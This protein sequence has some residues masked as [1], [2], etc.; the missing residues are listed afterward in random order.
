MKRRK[1]DPQLRA[2]VDRLLLS[3]T[4]D[5]G[6]RVPHDA[7]KHI[8][9][10]RHPTPDEFVGHEKVWKRI[11]KR[12]GFDHQKKIQQLPPVI[13]GRRRY[14][15]RPLTTWRLPGRKGSITFTPDKME[16]LSWN[17]MKT[18][19][20][21]AMPRIYDVFEVKLSGK[22]PMWAIHHDTLSW[23]PDKDWLLFLDTFFRWRSMQ[24]GGLRP[25]EPEDLQE[26]LEYVAAVDI[27]E[28][29]D[30]SEVRRRGAEQILPFM[31]KGKGTQLEKVRRQVWR[32]RNLDQKVKWAKSVLRFLKSNNVK[33]RDLDP[34]NLGKTTRGKTVI[35]NIAE[36]RSRGRRTG[37]TGRIS[38]TGG[39]PTKP[40]NVN[41]DGPFG[42]S[43]VAPLLRTAQACEHLLDPSSP[44]LESVQI[45][46]GGD[47][48]VFGLIHLCPHK[49]AVV[50]EAAFHMGFDPE[51]IRR[52][53]EK[54]EKF[55]RMHGGKCRKI[56]D[57]VVTKLGGTP[58]PAPSG[59]GLSLLEI[60]ASMTS[61]DVNKSLSAMLDDSN[62]V[63]SAVL[64]QNKLLARVMRRDRTVRAAVFL[65]SNNLPATV[66][67]GYLGI[68]AIRGMVKIAYL[69]DK[70][71]GQA[72]K[73]F[74]KV[75]R[76]LDRRMVN[77]GADYSPTDRLA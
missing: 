30:P 48:R 25:A 19:R 65:A 46:S 73:L 60:V 21:R 66:V 74:S 72:A 2:T 35:T 31:P 5:A 34:S 57:A 76:V 22:D 29:Y 55:A 77:E 59:D 12:L 56:Y 41:R 52:G 38:G 3:A 37:R 13:G 36:S 70:A 64:A 67:N 10:G 58:S 18:K 20:H 43:V 63:S 14:H 24:Y 40:I 69:S 7:W 53:L 33:H 1:A 39:A 16:A 44:L 23:P 11:A 28:I 4:V 68:E 51:T 26:F 45:F 71:G 54:L 8:K 75:Q 49:R 17:R 50:L 27:P 9:P 61:A 47:R 62:T 6:F 32:D 42:P 15:H